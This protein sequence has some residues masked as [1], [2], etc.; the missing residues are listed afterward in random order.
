MLEKDEVEGHKNKAG[1]E[2]LLNKLYQPLKK[3]KL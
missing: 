3:K 1:Q 2:N